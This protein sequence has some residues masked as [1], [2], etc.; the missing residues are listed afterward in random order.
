MD[1]ET[2]FKE[3]LDKFINDVNEKLNLLH[4]KQFI[5]NN[6]K[7]NIDVENE[8]TKIN[9]MIIFE[10]TLY[11]FLIDVKIGCFL[12]E[13]SL[14]DSEY[15]SLILK[16]VYDKYFNIIG[17]HHFEYI[18]K[19][20]LDSEEETTDST[21]KKFPLLEKIDELK[22]KY[23]FQENDYIEIVNLLMKIKTFHN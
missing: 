19:S 6:Y 16:N 2:E 22:L 15:F 1:I 8:I 17:H 20:I 14:N 13:D 23:N 21:I 3:T 7:I 12:S 10:N 9:E 11:A 18:L 4:K 5:L